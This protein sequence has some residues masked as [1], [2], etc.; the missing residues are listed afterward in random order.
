MTSPIDV[1][2]VEIR[3][4]VDDFDKAVDKDLNN[5]FNKLEQKALKTTQKVEQRFDELEQ[6]IH[7]NFKEVDKT[8]TT[9]F[10]NLEKVVV[11]TNTNIVEDFKTTGDK[12]NEHLTDRL[13]DN[14]TEH[15]RDI[16][17]EVENTTTRIR[18]RT[19]D[20]VD[21]INE[22]FNGIGR[23]AERSIRDR[24]RDIEGAIFDIGKSA[25]ETLGSSI[26]DNF[27]GAFDSEAL[28]IVLLAVLIP[29]AI[30]AAPLIATALSS[31]IIAAIPV[32]FIGVAIFSQ[33]DNPALQQA[34]RGFANSV[35]EIFKNASAGLVDNLIIGLDTI[36]NSFQKMEPTIN[37][38]FDALEPL[39]QPLAEGVGGFIEGIL[40]G[41]LTAI[42]NS[43][44]AI[45]ELSNGI[46]DLGT[47]LGDVFAQLSEDP[48]QLAGGMRN[49]FDII[50]GSIYFIGDALK[51]LMDYFDDVKSV[52][53]AVQR[54]WEGLGEFLSAFWAML[55][56]DAEDFSEFWGIMWDGI[57]QIA[58]VVIGALITAWFWAVGQ[59]EGG[60][61]RVRMFF[62]ELWSNIRDGWNRRV[63]EVVSAAVGLPGRIRGALGN[64]RNLLYNVGRDILRGLINGIEAQFGDLRNALNFVT[65]MIPN[66]KGP[67]D[68][69]KKLL[70]PT[71]EMIMGGLE[72][73][74]KKGEPSLEDTLGTVTQ[75]I[76]FTVGDGG[77]PVQV[78]MNFYGATPSEDDAK[79]LGE[80]AGRGIQNT[81]NK[82]AVRTAV[83][84]S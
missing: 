50:I 80:A 4:D 39:T 66:W 37:K 59:F 41:I 52:I 32:G 79:R 58:D 29:A 15:F 69:D 3:P 42:E 34:G 17:D 44:P 14:I 70:E 64:L 63:N 13:G 24:D 54:T 31:A 18:D 84:T 78:N 48:E 77:G 75:N 2:Y 62:S 10:N 74:I 65:N 35:K 71:G 61:F 46:A 30:L 23:D 9:T 27:K 33:L 20:S 49:L 6:E 73:G 55:T 60:V 5:T 43:G 51:W 40:P 19:R 83:R 12:I 67:A 68:K 81:L 16:G 57:R 47:A 22:D 8:T 21:G 38:I 28:K 11:K 26:L 82:R 1:A 25:G 36:L 76:G 53:E 56:G 72:A 45:E 7:E